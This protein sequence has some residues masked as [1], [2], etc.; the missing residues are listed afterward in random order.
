MSSSLASMRSVIQTMN[1]C[2]SEAHL[3][4]CC[5]TITKVSKEVKL[6]SPNDTRKNATKEILV[7][8]TAYELSE[9]YLRI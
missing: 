6:P 4:T 9:T 7:K 1:A 5:T 8:I 3:L 2:R